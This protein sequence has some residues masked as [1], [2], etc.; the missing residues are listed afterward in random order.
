MWSGN[1]E[2]GAFHRTGLVFDQTA[3][4]AEKFFPSP[5]TP[6]LVEAAP[7]TK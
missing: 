6:A 2:I 7:T 4:H 1:F 5:T 3:L